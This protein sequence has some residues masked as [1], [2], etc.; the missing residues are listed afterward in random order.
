MS[1]PDHKIAGSI[2][3]RSN[4]TLTITIRI[5][6]SRTQ[7]VSESTLDVAPNSRTTFGPD[8]GF[9]LGPADQVTLQN[10]TYSDLVQEIR[11]VQ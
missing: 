6:S 9:D 10:P 4:D 7:A 8:E 2:E 5:L 3:N 1:D 11:R